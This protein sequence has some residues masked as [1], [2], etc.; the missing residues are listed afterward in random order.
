MGRMSY[1]TH[2]TYP[3]LT[4]LLILRNVAPLAAKDKLTTVLFKVNHRM[5]GKGRIYEFISP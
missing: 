3:G 2:G 4:S 5:K 1:W